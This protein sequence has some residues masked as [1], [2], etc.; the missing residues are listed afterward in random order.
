MLEDAQLL[1]SI[2]QRAGVD[3]D[4][5]VSAARAELGVEAGWR[6]RTWLAA[7]WLYRVARG[8]Y[9]RLPRPLQKVLPRSLV[10]RVLVSAIKVGTLRNR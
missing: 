10:E 7:T 8:V 1:R 3:Q 2:A 5:F 4:A 9:R 6:A